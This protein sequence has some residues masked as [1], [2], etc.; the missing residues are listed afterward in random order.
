MR[1]YFKILSEKEL[2]WLYSKY[3]EVQ[4]ENLNGISELSV[5]REGMFS[6]LR[7]LSYFLLATNKIQD[8]G[9]IE[10]P[11][12]DIVKRTLWV[13]FVNLEKYLEK[14]ESHQRNFLE[15]EIEEHCT[16][17]KF[18]HLAILHTFKKKILLGR[19]KRQKL[20]FLYSNEKIREEA[21]HIIKQLTSQE[22]FIEQFITYPGFISPEFAVQAHGMYD[23]TMDEYVNVALIGPHYVVQERGPNGT[24]YLRLTG[25]GQTYIEELLVTNEKF[26]FFVGI[27]KQLQPYFDDMT[28]TDL[29]N[30]IKKYL[31]PDWNEKP[32]RSQ[33]K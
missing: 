11:I 13:L 17:V 1:P 30:F 14:Q 25:R 31:I 28:G 3:F 5:H 8:E 4:L 27:A 6:D 19:L 18:F 29:I 15:S 2:D 9:I 7:I 12:A 21:L 24:I 20:L 10:S 26:G 32:F 33:L 23:K 16:F 22:P